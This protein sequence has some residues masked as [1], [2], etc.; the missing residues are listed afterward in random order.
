MGSVSICIGYIT[1][2]STYFTAYGFS[3]R[4]WMHIST[5]PHY[6]YFA[7]FINKILLSVYLIVENSNL[8]KRLKTGKER[9]TLINVDF[10]SALHKNFKE[11]TT[12]Y[13][14]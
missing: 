3:L 7:V 9:I 13:M 5:D 11:R 6:P 4:K 1:N 2:H 12:K 10:F 14:Y 8:D